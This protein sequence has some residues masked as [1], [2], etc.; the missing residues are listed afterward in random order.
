MAKPEGDE[1]IYEEDDAETLEE[2]DE[3]SEDEEGIM[4]GQEEDLTKCAV[5]GKIVNNHNPIELEIK[6]KHYFFC[7]EKH[8][9][10][11]KKKNK[12]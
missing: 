12:Q 4:E 10:E 1:D 7:T 2:A 6:G 9:E 3:I 8:A 11:F 5:C